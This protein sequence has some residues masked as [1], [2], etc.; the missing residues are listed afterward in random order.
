MVRAAAPAE[1]EAGLPLLTV[2]DIAALD[3]RLSAR[4]RLRLGP[5]EK[6]G[7][8]CDDAGYSR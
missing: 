3:T 4:V 7:G 6:I 1:S 8:N 5:A 2:M